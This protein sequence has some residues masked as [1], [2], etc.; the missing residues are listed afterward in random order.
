V[1]QYA[2]LLVRLMST[3]P[4]LGSQ[5]ASEIG[6][7]PYNELEAHEFTSRTTSMIEVWKEW[8]GRVVDGQFLLRECLGASDSSVVFLTERGAEKQKAAI[9]LIPA[10]PENMA[11]QLARWGA[12]ARLSHPHLLRLFEAGHDEQASTPFLYV[13]M[14][15]AEENLAQ[16]VPQRELNP[17]EAKEL[18]RPVLDALVYI[19]G[20]RFVHSHL[21]PGNIMAVADQIKLSSDRLCAPRESGRGLEGLRATDAYDAPEAEGG[22]LTPASDVWS[23]GVTLVEGLTQRRPVWHAEEPTDPGLPEGIPEPF[24]DIARHCLRF[25]PQDRWTPARIASRLEPVTPEAE[26]PAAFGSPVTADLPA[27]AMPAEMASPPERTDFPVPEATVSASMPASIPSAPAPR[28]RLPKWTYLVP[29]ATGVFVLAVLIGSRTNSSR[30][31]SPHPRTAHS[32]TQPVPETPHKTRHLREKAKPA[33][34]VAERRKSAEVRETVKSKQASRTPAPKAA[35][36]EPAKRTPATGAAPAVLHQVLPDVPRSAR[37]TI[38]GHVR[39]GVKVV[40]DGS[41]N[42]ERAT[43]E[44]AGPSKYF[45]RLALEA[46]REWKFTP[47]SG[48]WILRFSFGRT[49]TEVVPQRAGR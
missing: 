11:S 17:E 7:L 23:L 8:E 24:F 38:H 29:L 21:K 1:G 10:N 13:V 43:L 2:T 39:V 22:T 35:P 41:G 3:L 26:Q 44:S 30:P 5:P 46:A 42:V 47:V 49:S 33:P 14:E 19:H 28:A 32:A 48:Q 40:V 12:A 37:N 34:A 31:P 27:P 36:S 16:I 18:L 25:D 4:D 6:S 15:Y 20:N 45:A 9:K